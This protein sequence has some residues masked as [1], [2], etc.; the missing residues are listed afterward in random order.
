MNIFSWLAKRKAPPSEASSDGV[1]NNTQNEPSEKDIFK[2]PVL[3]AEWVN[4][5]FLEA[6][7]LEENY[8]HLPNEE[9]RK[10]LNITYEQRERYIREIPTLRIAGVSLF[11]KQYYGDEF[12]LKYSRAIYPLLLCH[13][14]EDGYTN[15]QLTLLADAIEKYVSYAEN[16]DEKETCQC[17][18][19][20]L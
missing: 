14:Y 19:S 8:K 2:S 7:P 4:K 10:D 6:F 3:L 9:S 11:V 17:R 5:Y 16:R 20:T 12:W 13:I 15:E 18:E 1:T